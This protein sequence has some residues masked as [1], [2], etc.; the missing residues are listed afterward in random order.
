VK[1]PRRTQRA[2]TWTRRAARQAFYALALVVF[3]VGV[4]RE[5]TR[6]FFC[7]MMGDVHATPCCEQDVSAP[8]GPAIAD[9]ECCQPRAT[10][11]LPAAVPGDAAGVPAA[12]LRVAML[13][14][15]PP[16]FAPV[17][18][19]VESDIPRRHVPQSRTGPPESASIRR[20]KLGVYLL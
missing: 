6:Y 7:P 4:A 20:A 5:G 14:F 2:S 8:D 19:H 12:D 16:V 1:R 9:T 11:Q 17:V 10:G 3:I 15:E 13:A 18:A